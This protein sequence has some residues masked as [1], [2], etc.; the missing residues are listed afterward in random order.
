MRPSLWVERRSLAIPVSSAERLL[1]LADPRSE[2]SVD[3]SAHPPTYYGSTLFLFE[4]RAV[5]EAFAGRGAREATAERL[6]ASVASHPWLRLRILRSARE[7][8]ERRIGPG[9]LPGTARVTLE[10][11]ATDDAVLIEAS[12]EVPCGERGGEH[13][14]AL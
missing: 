6:A 13:A 11:K 14:V 12:I 2:G 10:A 8:A 3:R 7:E 4:M 1:A 9:L 5:R